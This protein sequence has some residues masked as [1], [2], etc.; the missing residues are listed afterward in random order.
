MRRVPTT[1]GMAL[2]TALFLM[3]D[4][5]R[6][7]TIAGGWRHSLA[8][9]ADK[10]IEAWGNND[11]GQCN[12]PAP[13]TDFKG[14]AGGRYHSLG[15]K[16]DGAI[17]AWGEDAHGQCATPAPNVD[18]IAIAA[19]YRHS[20][21]LKSDG[22]IV[23]WGDN[24]S[25]QC[26]VP[27]PN[28][29]F[30]AIDAG[31]FHSLGLKSDGTIVAWGVNSAGQCNV[32]APNSGFL[33]VAGG[34]DH[35]LGLKSDGT[36]VAWGSNS[37]G[38]CSVPAP[39]SGFVAVAAGYYHS[40]G[41]RADGTILAWGPNNNGECSVPAPNTDYVAIAAG[42]AHGLGQKPSGSIAAWGENTDAQC[43]VPPDLSEGI[44]PHNQVT[45]MGDGAA[46]YDPLTGTLDVN[47]YTVCSG[48]AS[49]VV[50]DEF[51]IGNLPPGTPV[52]I[53]GHM[54]WTVD[55]NPGC[56]GDPSYT[57]P[58][59]PAQVLV[60]EPFRL[61]FS[62]AA[63]AGCAC[64]FPPVQYWQSVQGHLWFSDLPVGAV[65][66]SC[67]GFVQ[68]DITGIG[69]NE[70]PP[71]PLAIHRLSPNPASGPFRAAIAVESDAPATLAVFDVSGRLVKR[72]PIEKI[73]RGNHRVDID[74][75]SSLSSGIYFVRLSQGAKVVWAKEAIV[76]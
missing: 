7:E 70:T 46:F 10:T 56:T 26:S 72:I 38:Q 22:T 4:L 27:E 65:V 71:A 45:T 3:T 37:F 28:T 44:C 66:T 50:T 69:A 21:G 15:L 34:L 52:T 12:V 30:I 31:E 48:S 64:G 5:A 24:A 43:D 18:F 75:P 55:S 41:L 73:G 63:Q 40:L 47:V 19:G 14:V 39:N 54:D 60:G 32:P 17:V 2:F 76:R 11:Y 74:L 9:R 6:C 1:L 59:F 25:G 67:Q 62:A 42:A 23:C 58:S 35:S 8:I 20:M 16:F 57:S 33:A 61:Q 29:D 53:T 68:G 49:M 51:V 13:N 36:I